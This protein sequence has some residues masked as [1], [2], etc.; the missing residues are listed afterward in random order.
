M[1]AINVKIYGRVIQGDEFRIYL[2]VIDEVIKNR[3][4]LNQ[5]Y[6]VYNTIDSILYYYHFISSFP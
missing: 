5:R 4:H 1:I 3:L 6:N 2:N